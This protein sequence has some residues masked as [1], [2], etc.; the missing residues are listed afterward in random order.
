MIAYIEGKVIKKELTYVVILV[1]N[2]GYEIVMTSYLLNKTQV[3]DSIEI[4]TYLHVR[5]DAWQLYGFSSWEEKDY[6]T[7]LLSVSGIGPRVG[8]GIISNSSIEKLNTAIKNEN[9]AY[10]TT[11]P[12]IGKKTAQRMIL[13]LKEK[14]SKLVSIEDS[15]SPNIDYNNVVTEAL[16]SLG[17]QMSEIEKVYR[18]VIK[19]NPQGDDTLLIKEAL[20]LLARV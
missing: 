1:N 11:L 2:I 5:E 8:M 14:V 15:G 10:L 4:H 20:K 6:F 16:L 7:L 17:Y 9:I 19:D 12:G 13:E 18:K 3:N